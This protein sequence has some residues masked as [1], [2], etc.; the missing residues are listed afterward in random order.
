VQRV[1]CVDC[2]Y[3]EEEISRKVSVYRQML[4]D[5]LQTSTGTGGSSGGGAVEKDDAGRPMYVCSAA[6]VDI[7]SVCLLMSHFL[8]VNV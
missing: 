8:N 5:N 2:R 4:M 6:A 3:D 1:E 7:L